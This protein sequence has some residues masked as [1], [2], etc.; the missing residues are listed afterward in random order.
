MKANIKRALI[1]GGLVFLAICIFSL[2]KGNPIDFVIAA[3]YGVIFG[4]VE[5]F[6]SIFKI[7]KKI[8]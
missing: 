3:K 2:I 8:W 5:F 7:E 6:L 4:V 1:W